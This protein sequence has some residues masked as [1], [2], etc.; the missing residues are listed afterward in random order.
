M[1]TGRRQLRRARAGGGLRFAKLLGTG[2]GRTFTLRDADPRHW[3]LLAVWEDADAADAFEHT[4]L[5]G[6]WART[7]AERLDVRMVPLASRGSWSGRQPFD[8]ATPP[9]AAPPA[10]RHEGPVA[11]ITRA[12]IRPT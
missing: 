7:A 3:G 6:G 12:R 10:T 8:D 1:A 2:D 4:A 5:H 9:G 11:A